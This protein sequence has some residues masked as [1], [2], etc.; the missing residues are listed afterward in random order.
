MEGNTQ[1]T[2][3]RNRL[4]KTLLNGFI[5]SFFPDTMQDFDKLA[6][7]GD[8]RV[9]YQTA[10]EKGYFDEK[11]ITGTPLMRYRD[12]FLTGRSLVNR[13]YAYRYTELARIALR[14]FPELERGE[15]IGVTEIKKRLSRIKETGYDVRTYST[16][17]KNELWNYWMQI[18]QKIRRS[19]DIYCPDVLVEIDDFNKRQKTS[20]LDHL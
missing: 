5:N 2:I 3:L 13:D 14:R 4:V 15:K 10:G 9:F 11:D 16:M 20:S 6:R 8:P 7:I 1:E 12:L 18:K 19:A 17:K